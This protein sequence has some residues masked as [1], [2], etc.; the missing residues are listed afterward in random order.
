MVKSERYLTLASGAGVVHIVIEHD[1]FK[2]TPEERIF[3]F[4]V[5]NVVQDFER[6][7]ISGDQSEKR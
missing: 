5:V 4:G 3:L 7:Q 6:Q 2:L 1:P